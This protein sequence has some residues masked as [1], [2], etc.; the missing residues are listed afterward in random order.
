MS[1]DT[2]VLKRIPYI[3]FIK[4][5]FAVIIVLFHAHSILGVCKG[6]RVAVEGFL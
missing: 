2:R 6:G 3:D 4:L 5:A 1:A